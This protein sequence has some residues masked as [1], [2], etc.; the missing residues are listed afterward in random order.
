MA[1]SSVAFQGLLGGSVTV[2]DGRVDLDRDGKVVGDADDTGTVPLASMVDD[3]TNADGDC[4]L[5]GDG[6]DQ[7][8][9]GT[10]SDYLGAGNGTDLVDGGDGNDL[11][12]GDDGTDVLL[13]GPHSDV[14]VGGTGDDSLVGGDGDDRLRGNEGADDLVGGSATGG[15]TD[16]QDVLLGGGSQDV[17]V[18]ENGIA[19]SA[20]IVAAV[21]DASV[22]WRTEASVPAAVTATTGSPLVFDHSAV[23]CGPQ[24]A[25]RWLTMV[26]DDGQAGIPA[27]S[28]GTPTAYDELYGG[29]ECDLVVG[30]PGDDLVR[31]GTGDD[32]VEA[33][34][35]ADIA[36]GDDGDDVVVGGSSFDPGLR[37]PFTTDRD[38]AGVPDAGDVIRGDGGPD[39]FDGSD[40]LAGD[41]AL[42]TRV[43]GPTGLNGAGPA[44]V[45]QLDDVATTS[46]VPA[47]TT[48]GGDQLSGDG[49][50]DALFGQGGGDGLNGGDAQDY[51]EGNDGPD[52]LA[53]GPGDDDLL[54]GSSSPDGRPLGS[55][56]TR[57]GDLLAPAFDSSAA[58]LLDRGA[59]QIDGDAG[60][61]VV[62]GDNGR[63]TRPMF[64]LREI[65]RADESTTVDTSGPDVITGGDDAD[66][67]FGEGGDDAID[68]GTADDHVEG[69]EGSDT[70]IGGLGSDTVIGG[71]SLS[72]DDR[73]TLD[74][75]VSRAR[76][77]LDG[78]DTI[79][80]DLTTPGP[81]SSDLLIGDNATVLGAGS[82]SLVQLADVATTASTP[83]AGTSGDDTI[84]GGEA[85]TGLAG[86]GDRVF[87][88]GGD[89]TIATGAGDD[90]VEGAAGADVISS[91]DGDDDVIGGAS[92]ADG[93][94]LGDTG[95][96][97]VTP[98]EAATDPSA[99]GLAD[100]NDTIDGGGSADV[101]LGDNG[102]ITR[103][104]AGEILV[105]GAS[106]S[107][108]VRQV[109]MAD[110]GPGPWAG[111]DRLTG[112]LGDDDLYGQFDATLT[113]RP[114]QTFLGQRV[115]GD[116]LDGGAG[117][118]ALLGDQG[119]DVPT[120]AA[121]L[122]ATS[123]TVSDST[124]FI[125]ELVR[126]TGT[127]VRVATL[128]QDTLGGDDVLVG[129]PGEDS[130]H[131]GAGKDVSNAGG[132]DDVVFAGSG[133]DALWGGTGH[134]RLFG[135]A[136]SDLL[137][138]KERARDPLL[139][140]L[141]A[142]VEDTDR[143]RRTAN[144]KDVLYGGSGA[145]GLQA[146]QGDG[147]ASH[148]VQG[149]RLIDWRGPVNHYEV[150][151]SGSGYGAVF[152]SVSSSMVSALRQLVT[153][154]GSVGS[155]ELAV[156]GPERLVP[157]PD[158]RRF[159][160]ETR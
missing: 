21:T 41:N 1:S 80:G 144:G 154:T 83:A 76:T 63:V 59:D 62:L 137:D 6:N 91:G 66:R 113:R 111:S 93:R 108:V 155:S 94:P 121:V 87:G 138:I 2:I 95:S 18:A 64:W 92:A 132:G 79:Y 30:S 8:G 158:S 107:H 36:Y 74:D 72:P 159:V 50:S 22:P 142:P 160:C 49:A 85:A 40:L 145:D 127:L 116:V 106:G 105:G 115:P 99:A 81:I 17:L 90:Y 51:L 153:A 112:G 7:L 37:T 125:R 4:V 58:G 20:S 48:S 114:Q 19:V 13:G 70:V 12:L 103:D 97:L 100:G 101:L 156:P 129:G 109:A 157:Y 135:G 140:R 84:Y 124:G 133:S 11:L 61:D 77:Q 57:L 118:D 9:G 143:L 134:D 5:A 15:A 122:G 38:G 141:V 136:G 68:A 88:Q 28:P 44:Y 89:D 23:G 71:S 130:L 53:G 65:A 54:G 148:R 10:G 110:E 39:G 123:R 29:D 98:V 102:R 96:R 78:G 47:A 69:N 32:L 35:G 16:G 73:G 149:D 150:C 46:S 117:D 67:L 75:A 31:G 43:A 34:P 52:A 3:D 82:T 119:V 56:G 42:A 147:G 27:A 24:P 152:N 128:S 45:L 25:T 86:T 139:W 151:R 26:K 55:S 14:I 126:P 131:A 146:D 33:G 60:A 120:P 104:G